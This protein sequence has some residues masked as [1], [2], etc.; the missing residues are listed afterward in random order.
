LL[1]AGQIDWHIF[2]FSLRS[3]QLGVEAKQIFGAHSTQVFRLAACCS[4][5]HIFASTPRGGRR[6]FFIEGEP[7]G[8][9]EAEAYAQTPHLRTG[10]AEHLCNADAGGGEEEA[11]KPSVRATGNKSES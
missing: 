3:D 4:H 7:W 10:T 2:G 5:Y 1:I 6:I 8:N 9:G 11:R